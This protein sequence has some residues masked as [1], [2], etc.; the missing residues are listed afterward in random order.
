MAT[1]LLQSIINGI[2][3]GAFYALIGMGLNCVY[4]VMGIITFCQGELLM[5]GMYISY[6]SLTNLGLDPYLSI[7]I[8]VVVLVILA[9][10]MQH[11]LITPMLKVKQPSEHGFSDHRFFDPFPEC[12]ANSLDVKL[13]DDY[14]AI[15]QECD[16]ARGYQHQFFEICQ[17]RR[18]HPDRLRVVRVL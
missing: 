13:S 9:A 12:G 6:F 11:F 3:I 1:D 10:L 2:L 5:L 18:M 4:S 16:H 14:N 17:L 8:V 15:Q 7:P